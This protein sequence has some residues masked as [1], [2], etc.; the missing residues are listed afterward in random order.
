MNNENDKLDKKSRFSIFGRKKNN[1][2]NNTSN[3]NKNPSS[4]HPTKKTSSSSLKNHT[5]ITPRTRRSVYQQLTLDG[6]LKQCSEAFIHYKDMSTALQNFVTKNNEAAE[7]EDKL[8]QMLSQYA[9]Q[10]LNPP[11]TRSHA[12]RTCATQLGDTLHKLSVM[13]TKM[14]E[15][16]AS[17]IC[18]RLA[19]HESD[20]QIQEAK[21]NH[22]IH[23]EIDY[24]IAKRNN[25]YYGD[26]LT[27]TEIYS[28]YFETALT[29]MRNFQNKLQHLPKHN[30]IPKSLRENF[31]S[32]NASKIFGVNVDVI[33]QRWDEPG[34]IPIVLEDMLSV[35]ERNFLQVEG[36]MRV[37]GHAK[38]MER[39]RDMLNEGQKIEYI[40]MEITNKPHTIC[41]LVKM[42]ARELPEP[43]L[44]FELF[45]EFLSAAKQSSDQLAVEKMKELLKEIP[46]SYRSCL[47][48]ICQF[49]KRITEREET[50]K[51]NA[52]NLSISFGMNLLR[53]RPE[54]EDAIV[55]AQ[56]TKYINKVCELLITHCGTLFPQDYS[57]NNMRGTIN[58][59][60]LGLV[61][62]LQNQ[63]SLSD[64]SELAEEMMDPEE[65]NASESDQT[66]SS[67]TLSPR[68]TDGNLVKR[69]SDLA[70]Q[71]LQ[72]TVT[73]PT[74]STEPISDV[75]IVDDH[76]RKSKRQG[77]SSLNAL[78]VRAAIQN[79]TIVAVDS[80]EEGWQKILDPNYNEYYYYN[81]VTQQTTWQPPLKK[82]DT[83]AA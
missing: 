46:T 11:D 68:D 64:N 9:T 1:N 76:K 24:Q 83:K 54:E 39:L 21:I 18:S 8:S 52:T 17:D 6:K 13:R 81:P 10:S 26:L 4:T 29:T 50:T 23:E 47:G 15:R 38:E 3:T 80:I 60:E 12:V 30:D 55:L 7:A 63:I 75:T 16:L 59:H 78:D 2:N 56:N 79:G 48:R 28:T 42:F 66:L 14:D 45:D 44:T 43:L 74:A 5:K 36:L 65:Q 40:Q 31:E 49:F 77:I 27:I 33:L 22:K 73:S 71:V 34:P 25:E 57:L 70:E 32:K 53:M 61:K 20:N 58:L 82:V 67:N 62:W 41:G 69:S 35:L 19:T 37:P 72:E 51:M